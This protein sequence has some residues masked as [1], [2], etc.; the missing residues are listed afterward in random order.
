MVNA[1]GSPEGATSPLLTV[2]LDVPSPW[3]DA[4]GDVAAALHAAYPDL[5]QP[6]FAPHISL[7]Q[8]FRSTTPAAAVAAVARALRGLPAVAI[9]VDSIDAFQAPDGTV[10]VVYLAVAAPW[11]RLAHL[12]L[13]RETAVIDAPPTPGNPAFELLGFRPHITLAVLRE[14]P[15]PTAARAAIVSRAAVLWAERR[16]QGTGFTASTVTLSRWQP[17]TGVETLQAFPLKAPA[18]G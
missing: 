10:E 18:G 14:L 1:L 9:D 16:P 11:L 4:V 6:L 2:A 13:M 17:P 7:R 5:P 8:S 3:S 15:C 12:R